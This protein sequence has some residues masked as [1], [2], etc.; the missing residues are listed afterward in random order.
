MEFCMEQENIILK[1][2]S[3]LLEMKRGMIYTRQMLQNLSK[4]F[5]NKGRKSCE[6]IDDFVEEI[7]RLIEKF[8]VFP[9]HMIWECISEMIPGNNPD[10]ENYILR[11]ATKKESRNVP[12]EKNDAPGYPGY[13]YLRLPITKKEFSEKFIDYFKN[14]TL[15]KIF[16][17]PLKTG[18]SYF[19]LPVFSENENMPQWIITL[20]FREDNIDSVNNR[21][22]FEFAEHFS[23]QIGLA[24]D[25]FQENVTSRLLENIDYKLG[26]ENKTKSHSTLDQLKIISKILALEIDADWC[27]FSLVNE[28]EQENKLTLETGNVELESR[29]NYSL[30]DHANIMVKCF[31]GDHT[32]RISGRKRLEE[33][34]NTEWMKLIEKEIRTGRKRRLFKAGKHHFTPYV[35]FEHALF[36]PISFKAKKLGLITLFRGQKTQNPQPQESLDYV[37]RP[38][39]Q[40]ETHLLKKVQRHIFNIFV[41]HDAVQKRM[42]DIRNIIAQVISPIS[43]MITSTDKS[44]P[45]DTSAEKIT[46]VNLHEKLP[47]VNAL[48]RI[49]AQY[50]MN[51]EILLDI[52]TRNI[53]LNKEKIPD[54][55]KYLIDFARIY[56]PLIRPKFIHIHVTRQTPSDICLEVDKDL[57]H[58]VMAN[59]LDNAIKYSFDPEDRL[60]HG[61]QA[62]PNS[63]EDIENVLITA[64]EDEDSVTITVSSY[65]IEIMDTESKSI[66]D[67]EFRGVYAPDRSKGTGIGLYLAKEIIEMHK[68]TIAIEHGISVNNN[69][70]KITLPKREKALSA[71]KGIEAD[72]YL[73]NNTV[74]RKE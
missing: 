37:T 38:F 36:F 32:L 67:K 63:M 65:G 3:H 34:F 9:Y 62:K 11:N 18:Y 48:S 64:L 35:L 6:Y 49:A 26:G 23:H 4:I 22:F 1:E 13:E 28:Q 14:G 41:S 39:S 53:K 72:S 73:E 2:Q 43:E 31:T 45:G 55:R 74:E 16:E 69:V 54:L 52:D 44:I 5:R 68:G 61:L 46:A 33:I 8:E 29:F 30:T 66:F 47:Y 42:R 60:F 70:F 15:E 50:I 71:K 59:I 25:K 17:I 40:F 19:N 58:V 10:E 56:T 7:S 24:W 21:D 12:L 57:F 27:A 51:F 20:V